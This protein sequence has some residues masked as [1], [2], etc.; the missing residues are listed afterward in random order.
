MPQRAPVRSVYILLLLFLI[1]L[2]NFFD[3]T[4]PAALQD[5]VEPRLRAAAMAVYFFFQYVLGAGFGTIVTG[6]LSVCTQSRRWPRLA[7]VK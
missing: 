2:M 6:A 7:P 1:N 4:I 5:V 3:R